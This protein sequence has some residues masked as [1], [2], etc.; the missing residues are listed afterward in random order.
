MEYVAYYFDELLTGFE[1][2]MYYFVNL[3]DPIV[4][5]ITL[6]IL[7]SPIALGYICAARVAM[8]KLT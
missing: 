5:S 1:K 2:G 6:F 7:L 8:F 3:G 4:V